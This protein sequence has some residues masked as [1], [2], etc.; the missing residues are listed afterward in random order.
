[1]VDPFAAPLP[2]PTPQLQALRAALTRLAGSTLP[3]PA[4]MALAE[5]QMAL[6][7]L[8]S[9]YSGAVDRSVFDALMAMAGPEVAPELVAQM[10]ADLR[11][12]RLALAAA[13]DGANWA[14]I[15]AQTHVLVALA[16]S[17][18]ARGLEQASQALNL[19]AH[20]ADAIRVRALGPGILAGLDGLIR[21]VEAADSGRAAGK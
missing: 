20:E 2:D 7:A 5:A 11:A 6:S 1:M 4:R 13:L 10:A 8:E 9:L 14:G 17:A 19:A 3:A 18:G 12:V 16:G 21:F 15:R